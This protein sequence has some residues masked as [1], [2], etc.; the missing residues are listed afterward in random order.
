MCE[1]GASGWGGDWE[2][3]PAEAVDGCSDAMVLDSAVK[4]RKTAALKT[5]KRVGLGHVDTFRT[6][7]F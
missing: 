1:H 2:S 4:A 7:F 6:V 5:Y 3:S